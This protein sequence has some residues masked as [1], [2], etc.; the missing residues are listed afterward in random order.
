MNIPD[1]I[2]ENLLSVLWLKILKFFPGS[3]QPGSTT[4][5]DTNHFRLMYENACLLG[6]SGVR[7]PALQVW[8]L[9]LKKQGTAFSKR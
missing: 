6:I 4:L 1:L 5:P 2:F 7:L 9:Y 8:A 3:C